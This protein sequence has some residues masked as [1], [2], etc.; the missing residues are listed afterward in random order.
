MT[1]SA[2]PQINLEQAK[3]LVAFLE[4]GEQFQAQTLLKQITLVDHDEIF[5]E[6]GK[7]T[8]QLHDSLQSFQ[9]D[10]KLFALTNESIPDAKKRLQHVIEMTEDAA[11]KT[12][13]AVEAS[14]PIAD[15]LQTGLTSIEPSWDKLMT[16]DL[17][18]GEFKS[19]CHELNAFI[20]QAKSDSNKLNELLTEVLMAQG[21]QDLTGQ[22]IR[23]VIELVHEVEDSLINVL[24]VFSRSSEQIA[25]E[26]TA[27][28]Q[29]QK[30]VGESDLADKPEGPV[31]DAKTRD[32]VVSNQDEVDDLLSSLGF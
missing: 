22:V 28:S 27:L 7:L 12:M 29:Q 16:R 25:L 30:I 10:T 24:T 23:R 26:Q 19:L 11:N 32:D 8:R 4:N 14:L 2:M 1:I 18:L 5:G 21:F 31:L 6:V 20:L 15:N 3:Q 13:D 9:L 17:K